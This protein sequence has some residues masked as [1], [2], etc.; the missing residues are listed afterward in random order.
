VRACLRQSAAAG[1]RR[2]ARRR[3][4]GSRASSSAGSAAR[5]ACAYRRA[6]TATRTPAPATTTGRPRGEAPSAPSRLVGLRRDRLEIFLIILFI[7]TPREWKKR[8][9]ESRYQVLF[10]L[11]RL[12]RRDCA[13]HPVY[14]ILL[15]A[16]ICSSIECPAIWIW[17]QFGHEKKEKV[18]KPAW[19]AEIISEFHIKLTR[20]L[21]TRSSRSHF[22]EG[23]TAV[24]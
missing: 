15:Y 7:I 2:G 14:T 6:P 23:A 16:H 24:I 20:Y 18:M 13:S 5:R 21:K 4:T 17:I 8:E 9:S 3:R 1:A 10:L 19:T 12:L 22:E 11:D